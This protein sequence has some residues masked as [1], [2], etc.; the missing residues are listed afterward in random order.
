M[1]N[2]QQM[3]NFSQLPNWAGALDPLSCGLKEDSSN[4]ESAQYHAPMTVPNFTGSS[5]DNNSNCNWTGSS[6]TAGC[7]PAAASSHRMWDPIPDAPHDMRS[8]VLDLFS[9]KAPADTDLQP[10][11]LG[12]SQSAPG[13]SKITST[14]DLN[15]SKQQD[16]SA[17]SR[18]RSHPNT[19]EQ[20]QANA[21]ESQKRFRMR[22]KVLFAS[23]PAQVGCACL[24]ILPSVEILT[25]LLHVIG[26]VSGNRGTAGWH[27]SRAVQAQ[28]AAS[29]T[30]EQESAA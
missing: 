16:A 8:Q 22:Q 12:V 27:C 4:V 21:R 9:V 20:K 11:Q 17:L 2:A 23:Q 18:T 3:Q 28:S 6:H 24:V 26:K 5:V 14:E 10:A 19:A 29:A 25:N 1:H 30:G 7:V 13:G 15:S